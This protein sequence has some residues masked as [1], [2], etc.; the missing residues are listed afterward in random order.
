MTSEEAREQVRTLYKLI[1]FKRGLFTMIRNIYVPPRALYQHLYFEG[2]FDVKLGNCE[3]AMLNHNTSLE[4]LVFWGGF[5]G[6]EKSS[7][8]LWVRLC[9]LSS[10]IL[11]IG[12]NTGLYSLIAKALRPRARVYGFEPIPRL[13]R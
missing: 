10:T 6:Y 13:A 1:P 7:I 5:S 2:S 12:A 9:G 4:T 11:D 3:F 8:N